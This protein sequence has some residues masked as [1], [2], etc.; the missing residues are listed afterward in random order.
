MIR[1][2]IVALLVLVLFDGL[3]HE[4][5]GTLIPHQVGATGLEPGTPTMSR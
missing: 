1:K 2:F 3:A 5:T 4:G